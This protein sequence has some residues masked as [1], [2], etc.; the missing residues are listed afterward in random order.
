MDTKLIVSAS[1]HLRSEETTQSLMAN[2]IVALC[3]CVV[4]SAIIFGARACWS[5]QCPLWHAW[6]LSGCTASC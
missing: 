1:P 4:A 2:V 5:L 6:P 3:P